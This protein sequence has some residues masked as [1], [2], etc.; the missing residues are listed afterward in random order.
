MATFDDT[1]V[2]VIVDI[3]VFHLDLQA[4][5]VSADVTNAGLKIM[6]DDIYSVSRWEGIG[7]YRRQFLLG[8]GAGPA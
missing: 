8:K 2:N 7:L 3:N 1:E 5:W 4:S 6:H